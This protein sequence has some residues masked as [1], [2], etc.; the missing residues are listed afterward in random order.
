M[1]NFYKIKHVYPIIR[2][3]LKYLHKN[4]SFVIPKPIIKIIVENI[5][6][7]NYDLC[8]VITNEY[9]TYSDNYYFKKIKN[10]SLQIC[11][12]AVKQNGN[13]LE[14][15]K[16]HKE[17][18]SFLFGPKNKNLFLLELTKYVWKL[19]KRMVGH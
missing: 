12:E 10:P 19:L 8:Q 9:F 1:E 15:I 11:L 17:K 4:W 13:A 7:Y 2:L 6:S 14:Y 5:C 3:C 18:K 16:K